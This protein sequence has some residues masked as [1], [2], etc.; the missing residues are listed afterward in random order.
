MLKQFQLSN[1]IIKRQSEGT[2]E[3]MLHNIKDKIHQTYIIFSAMYSRCQKQTAEVTL[4][5]L[6][7]LHQKSKT[8]CQSP[9][10]MEERLWM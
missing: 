7:V 10:K 2:T 4:K 1:I 9:N 5:Q 8:P 6:T 3:K